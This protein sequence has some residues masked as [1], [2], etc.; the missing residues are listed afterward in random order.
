MK[1]AKKLLAWTPRSEKPHAHYCVV[2]VIEDHRRKG[3]FGVCINRPAPV[4]PCT[5]GECIDP[6]VPMF[7]GGPER[8]DER[9][10]LLHDQPIAADKRDKVLGNVFLSCPM[11]LEQLG[12]GKGKMITGYFH[13]LPG[14]LEEEVRLGWWEVE[15]KPT[16]EQILER[17]SRSIWGSLVP[18]TD[19]LYPSAN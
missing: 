6:P 16:H 4:F 18:L 13:W 3:T 2:L 1:Y 11:A 7:L 5:C 8:I 19:R 9:F 15:D 14:E 10:F 17:D 12:D